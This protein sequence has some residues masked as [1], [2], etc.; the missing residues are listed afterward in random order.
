MAFWLPGWFEALV[1]EEVRRRLEHCFPCPEPSRPGRVLLLGSTFVPTNPEEHPPLVQTVT[2]VHIRG[3]LPGYVSTG[4]VVVLNAAGA[5][6][7]PQ[8]APNTLTITQTGLQNAY[9]S[10]EA[11]VVLVGDDGMA[12]GDA[13][14]VAVSAVETGTDD[15]LT[16]SGV[17]DPDQAGSVDGG[18]LGSFGPVD[19][20]GDLPPAA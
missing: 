17:Y 6:M 12:P 15:D 18:A 1:R 3:D 8:P 10:A 13:W 2:D 5:P 4:A 14:S 7:V 16:I 20:A 9:L 11:K 19:S